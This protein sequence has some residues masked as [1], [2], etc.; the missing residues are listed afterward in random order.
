MASIPR[1]DTINPQSPDETPPPDT[2]PIEQPMPSGPDATPD[3]GD[4][5]NPGR[6]P[7]ELPPQN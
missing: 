1:P 4:T 2:G 6:G 5:V 3:G 7:A